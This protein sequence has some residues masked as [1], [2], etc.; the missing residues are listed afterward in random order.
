MLDNPIDWMHWFARPAH[1]VAPTLVGMTL[2]IDGIGGLIV[3]VE[4]YERDDPASHSFRGRTAGNAAMFG[5]P[6][7][8]YV[9]RSYGLHWCFNIVCEEGSAVLLRALEPRSGVEAMR[10]RRCGIA[11]RL[12]CAGPGR[13]A[14][15]LA[16]DARLN[17]APLFEAPFSLRPGNSSAAVVTGPRIGITKARELPWRFGAADSAFLSRPFGGRSGIQP[18]G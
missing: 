1:L 4:A 7:H 18:S 14:Q 5:P 6:A 8:A 15:A 17:G 13:L 10:I 3:E 12:L 2:E 11:D 9:Y 16:I